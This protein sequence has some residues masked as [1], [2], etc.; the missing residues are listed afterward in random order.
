MRSS[1]PALALALLLSGCGN[2]GAAV[3]ASGAGVPAP[4]ATFPLDPV[5]PLLSYTWAGDAPV[6]AL[7][8]APEALVFGELGRTPATRLYLR[9][10]DLEAEL[11]QQAG[12][13][14]VEQTS[15]E[16]ASGRFGGALAFA[17][18]SRLVLDAAEALRAPGE[19]WSLELWL[20]PDAHQ[21]GVILSLVGLL[22]VASEAGGRVVASTSIETPEGPKNVLARSRGA[23]VPGEWN[24][25][26]VVLDTGLV[27]HLRVVLN[28]EVHSERL[29]GTPRRS[30]ERLTLGASSGGR[31]TLPGAIDELRLQGRVANS[32]E[33]EAH[34]RAAPRPLQR[35][36]VQYADGVEER[37]FWTRALSVPRLAP[38]GDWTAGELTHLRPDEHGLSWVAADWQRIPA[39]DPPLAR[40][41]APVVPVG[42]EKL[43]LFSGEVRD[44]HYGRITNSPD[45]WLFDM[46]SGAWEELDTPVAPPGRCHQPAAYSPDHDVVLMTGGWIND[47]NP[48]ELLSDLWLFHVKERRWEERHPADMPEALSDSVVVYHPGQKVFVILSGAWAYTYDPARD[49]MEAAGKLRPAGAARP[50]VQLANGPIGAL[51]PRTN[52]LW[53]FGGARPV[54]GGEEF[55]DELASFD[56]ETRVLTYHEGPRPSARVRGAFAWDPVRARFV[57][58][59]GVREQASQR[60]DDLWTFDP[61][62]LRW[63]ELPYAGAITRRGGYYGLGHS[64]EQDRFYLLTGRHSKERFLEEAWSLALDPQAEGRG[65][66]LFDRA[67]FPGEA[68]WFLESEP[69][70]AELT[71]RFRA[72]DDGRNFGPELASCPPT[73]RYV[74]VDLRLAPGPSGTAPRV[75]ALGFRAPQ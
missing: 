72:S 37:E 49:V 71:L 42:D 7:P 26:G 34:W 9:G 58:F 14:I 13:A 17:R 53:L 56:L 61:A 12:W 28:G 8:G 75:R 21:A 64:A 47:R 55:S 41:T 67:A 23:L 18:G 70:D 46:R 5:R 69:A 74:E 36:T 27:K 25:L 40:T 15:L 73:G 54:E 22:E 1:R 51:D 31:S 66:W 10:E 29:E 43:F 62:T 20:R 30:F 16:P 6:T 39:L 52:L 68:A 48:G 50:G 45:T 4:L 3:L 35:L 57:L 65:R 38:G 24:H 32:S 11:G 44:S 2:Q 33:F 19:G 59:G 63:E 60:F